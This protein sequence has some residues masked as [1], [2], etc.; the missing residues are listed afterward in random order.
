VDFALNFS[1]HEIRKKHL[2][3]NY[4]LKKIFIFYLFILKKKLILF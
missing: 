4:K 1:S 3:S 2:K